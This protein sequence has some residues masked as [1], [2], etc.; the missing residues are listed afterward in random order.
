M[1]VLH[2]LLYSGM[3]FL[4]ISHMNEALTL[5]L[6]LIN[7][8]PV[9]RKRPVCQL[10][11]MGCNALVRFA[12][13]QQIIHHTPTVKAGDLGV[14]AL[15]RYSVSAC[16]T[17]REEVVKKVCQLHIFYVN[18]TKTNQSHKHTPSQP[19]AGTVEQCLPTSHS[20]W[21]F[22]AP[23]LLCS[24]LTLE[25]QCSYRIER[26]RQ[27]GPFLDTILTGER[28]AQGDRYKQKATKA[29]SY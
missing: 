11:N 13:C 24:Y 21:W 12:R 2:I 27:L 29:K 17:P 5:T 19:P 7:I 22:P 4:N 15:T 6:R 26:E 8:L 16:V 18:I 3:N 23:G 25:T 20:N 9:M 1:M 28:S 10:A 14:K